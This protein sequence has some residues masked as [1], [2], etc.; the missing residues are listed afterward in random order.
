MYN[1]YVMALLIIKSELLRLNRILCFLIPKAADISGFYCTV[2]SLSAHSP[3][4]PD[5]LRVEK[6]DLV[7]PVPDQLVGVELARAPPGDVP[8]HVLAGALPV[9]VL[10]C[11]V[12]GV[13]KKS[14]RNIKFCTGCP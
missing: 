2:L 13:T 12:P 14:T 10:R 8:G 9:A 5:A 11:V 6:E 7:E 3:E 1:L 4:I